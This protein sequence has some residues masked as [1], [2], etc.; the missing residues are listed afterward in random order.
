[1][2]GLTLQ[3]TYKLV[4]GFEIPV[5]GFGVGLAFVVW[6][7]AFQELTFTRPFRFTRRELESSRFLQEEIDHCPL[8]LPMSLR[9]SL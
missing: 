8:D 2:T 4:S 6:E 3:S 9:K 1:M 7:K 5:V